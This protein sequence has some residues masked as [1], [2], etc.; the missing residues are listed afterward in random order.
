[1]RGQ[2][3]WAGLPFLVQ[4][5]KPSGV[6]LAPFAGSAWVDGKGSPTLCRLREQAEEGW[7]LSLGRCGW[8]GLPYMVQVVGTKR[9]GSCTFH[10]VGVCGR[11]SPIWCRRGK[12]R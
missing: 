8:A 6:G 10:V 7:R 9:R 2:R 1:M 12:P 3:E 5:G 11:G 4:V